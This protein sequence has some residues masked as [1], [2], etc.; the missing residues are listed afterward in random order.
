MT[1]RQQSGP[2]GI[3]KASLFFD[4]RR[5]KRA[6]LHLVLGAPI[7][8]APIA[9]WQNLGGNLGPEAFLSKGAILTW[10]GGGGW[11]PSLAPGEE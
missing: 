5:E 6:I 1:Q 3:R 9:A 8:G 4:G 2:K 10:A 11:R 7:A